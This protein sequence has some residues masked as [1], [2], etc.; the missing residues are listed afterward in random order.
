MGAYHDGILAYM[1]MLISL[2]CLVPQCLIQYAVS[3][4]QADEFDCGD[5]VCIPNY[6][7][8][9]SYPD[10]NDLSDEHDCSKYENSIKCY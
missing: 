6:W 8:C 1:W 7:Q 2:C 10:C 3:E 4:C 9:D 5:G